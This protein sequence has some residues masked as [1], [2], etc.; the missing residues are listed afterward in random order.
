MP[1][2]LRR[3]LYRGAVLSARS[4]LPLA[5]P[6]SERL[7][8]GV[9]GRGEAVERMREW[10]TSHLAGDAPLV[11]FHAPSVGE[12]LMAQA[13]IAALRQKRPDVRVAFTHFSPS[14]ERVRDALGADVA[15][16]LPWDT[17]GDVHA[18]LE[19]LRPAALVFVRTEIW[20]E[21][22]AQ[23][24]ARGVP[25][26]LVNATLREGSSRLRPAARWLLTPAYAGLAAVGAASAPDGR[27][28]ARLGV[29][30][31]RVFVTGDARFDQVW[32]R[33][34]GRAEPALA[35]VGRERGRFTLVA[36]STW[37]RDHRVLAPAWVEAAALERMR[38]IVAPHEPD[39]RHLAEVERTLDAVGVPHLRLSEAERGAADP[40]LEE[41]AV[42]VDRLGV[43]ADLYR[44]ADA[45]Y[46]G[47]GF[48]S[49]GLH[50]VVEPA[51]L[52]V[53]VLFGP[54]HGNAREAAE[55]A[56]AGGGVE[57]RGRTQVV[58]ALLRFARSTAEGRAAGAA[59]REY[60]E[61]RLGGAA[62]A[63]SL[64]D[65]FLPGPA[66]GP[67]GT[68]KPGPAPGYGVT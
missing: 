2:S 18:A 67:G 36:G 35:G 23:A 10:A 33:L 53:P 54:R 13:T 58:A 6:A 31:E 39:G 27:L 63:A 44:I 30:P 49:A 41:A 7:R 40:A 45:A 21:L 64:V 29:P 50:S 25:C 47:G 11:W 22:V 15:A 16:Y 17:P 1:P 19:A 68:R 55:L 28:F 57:V 5:A 3:S 14:A 48:G 46:V 32:S 34:A 56:A 66:A 59:A 62:A 51:A 52:G 9:V 24:R 43:L 4:L 8:R 61:S 12:A 20:P 60:V 37:P 65:R 38:L 42:V 26:L